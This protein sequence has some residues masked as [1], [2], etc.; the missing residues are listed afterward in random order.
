MLEYPI[1]YK[2]Q[3]A[4]N[5]C[6]NMNLGSSETIRGTFILLFHNNKG[7]RYSPYYMKI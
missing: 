2:G 1:K 5:Q 4:G 3:S 7:W 6:I